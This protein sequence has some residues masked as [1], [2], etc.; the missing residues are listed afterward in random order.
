VEAGAVKA[1]R[2]SPPPATTGMGKRQRVAGVAPKNH[3]GCG[4][5]LD[6]MNPEERQVTVKE[7]VQLQRFI[8]RYRWE[9]TPPEKRK[10]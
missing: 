4:A 7:A 9:N 8:R 6:R 1:E 3:P 10:F 2:S 5:K